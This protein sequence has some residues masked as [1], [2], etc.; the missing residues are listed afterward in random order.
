VFAEQR[1]R[2]NKI[3]VILFGQVPFDLISFAFAGHGI[4]ACLNLSL[5][6]YIHWIILRRG[7]DVSLCSQIVF[8]VEFAQP[9]VSPTGDYLL[10][11][12]VH[13]N[14][15][16]VFGAFAHRFEAMKKR[17][18][19]HIPQ[20]TIQIFAN[21]TQKQ[22]IFVEERDAFPNARFVA[23]KSMIQFGVLNCLCQVTLNNCVYLPHVN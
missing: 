8:Q 17:F 16:Y 1:Q 20:T 14:R 3:L 2:A 21:A 5:I 7:I 11:C 12:L 10:I 15:P 22:S 18:V 13:T 19:A 4:V 6:R 23:V 9:P